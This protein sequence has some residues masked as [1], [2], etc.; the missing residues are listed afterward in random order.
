MFREWTRAAC[1]SA[2]STV[3][4]LLSV[5]LSLSEALTVDMRPRAVNTRNLG[6]VLRR[7]EVRACGLEPA[8]MLEAG[9]SQAGAAAPS[10]RRPRVSANGRSLSC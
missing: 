3:R 4:W 10:S 5:T 6:S 9:T 7:T 2:A 1:S 8:A